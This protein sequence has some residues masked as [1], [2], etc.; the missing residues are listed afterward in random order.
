MFLHQFQVKV[1]KIISQKSVMI[2]VLFQLIVF[3]PQK[4]DFNFLKIT[5]GIVILLTKMGQ[6]QVFRFAHQPQL[7][8]VL[9]IRVAFPQNLL[10]RYLTIKSA[11]VD[12]YLRFQCIFS[13]LR[14]EH[15]IP[16]ICVFFVIYLD[17]NSTGFNAMINWNRNKLLNLTLHKKRS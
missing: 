3:C 8:S 4:L 9:Y 11:F 5:I 7:K 10:L 16:R 14:R 2:K 6:Y 13:K 15:T 12:Q 17:D 1:L